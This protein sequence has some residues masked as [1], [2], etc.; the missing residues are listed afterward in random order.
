MRNGLDGKVALVTGGGS[1][2]GAAISDALAAAGVE[3]A[4][5]DVRPDAAARTVEAVTACGGTA[6]PLEMDVSDGSS[7]ARAFDELRASAGRLDILINTAAID[8]AEDVDTIDEELWLRE[9]NVNLAGA[10]LTSRRALPM[11]KAQGS[12]N[13][14]NIASTASLRAWTGASAYHASK[15]GLLGFTR[16]LH[17]EARRDNIK[18]TAVISGGM[19]TPFLLD[20]FS[21]ID[22][23]TLQDPQNV[24]RTVL[25]VLDQP[26]DCVIPEIM[27]LPMKET[28]WP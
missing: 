19:R 15:W 6:W 17:A 3:V 24:A 20:R 7:V 9:V 13:I 16:A 12:G 14:V 18:V 21:D 10:F 26:E 25:F 23:S 5:A 22:Q 11:M 27:V 8:V 28:S 2:L 1:G 4:G